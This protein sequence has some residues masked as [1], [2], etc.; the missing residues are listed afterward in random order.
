MKIDQIRTYLV[1]PSQ[2]PDGW[3]A[4]KPF[5][6]VR[7][8]TDVGT[9]GWG[10]A[11]LLPGRELVARQMIVA[12]APLLLEQDPSEIRRFRSKAVVGFADKRTGIDSCCGLSALEIALWDIL[13]KSLNAPAYRLL[14]GRR[15]ESVPL[16]VATWSERRP[17]IDLLVGRA[18]KMKADGFRAVKIYPMEFSPLAEAESCVRR[19]REAIG[20]DTDLLIDLNALDDPYLAIRAARAFEPYQPFWFEEPVSSDDLDALGRVRSASSL[21]I[22]SGERHGGIFRFREIPGARGR[23]RF[24]PGH[25]RLRRH[26][27][28]SRDRRAGPGVLGAGGAAPI[29]QHDGRDGRDA[30]RRRTDPEPAGRGIR[31]GIPADQRPVGSP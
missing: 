4:V 8:T 21:R 24:E 26:P 31:A 29:Q 25:L 11:Y 9:D 17:G 2:S 14:G 27:R 28:V 13:G 12:L 30:P 19:V 20:W 6:L 3:T 5:L 1:A 22:V 23:G 7:I 10:E 18:A 16:Y 15:R